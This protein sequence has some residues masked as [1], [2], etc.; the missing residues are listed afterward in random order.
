MKLY[1]KP[2]ACSTADHIALEWA[3]IPFDFEVVKDLKGADFLE[4]NPAGAVPA[5]QDGD[6]VLTQNAA[7]MQYISDHAPDAALAKALKIDLTGLDALEAYYARMEADSG[8]QAALESE[9][10]S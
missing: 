1:T 7:I 9:G 5:L 3:G 10:L 6:F 8:V 2:G 4:I